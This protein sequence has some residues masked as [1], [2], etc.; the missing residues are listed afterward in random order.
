[1]AKQSWLKVVAFNSP[2]A[3]S[4]RHK[5]ELSCHKAR[6]TPVVKQWFE[7]SRSGRP[8]P[9]QEALQQPHGQMASLA[10]IS[11]QEQRGCRAQDRAYERVLERECWAQSQA[12]PGAPRDRE[13]M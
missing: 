11:A 9:L 5:K 4:E 8:H 12:E 7:A 13:I 3:L 1:M 6:I 10:S 2:P